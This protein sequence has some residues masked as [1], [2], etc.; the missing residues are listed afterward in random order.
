MQSTERYRAFISYS[1]A[2]DGQLAPALQRGLHRLAKPWYRPPPWRTF[3]DQTSLSVTPAL[4]SSIEQALASSGF[5]ILLASPKAAASPWVQREIDWWLAHRPKDRLLLALT[6]GSLQWDREAHDFDPASSNALPSNLRGV[7]EQEPLWVDL[8]W[9]RS[10][11]QVSLRHPAFRN[12]V[13]ELAAPLH[14]VDKERLVGEDMRQQRRFVRWRNSAIGALATV[15]LIAVGAATI[16]VDRENQAREEARLALSR[17]LAAEAT[18]AAD[19]Q[20]DLGLVL[21]AQAYATRPTAQTKS[22]L[23][24]VLLRSPHLVS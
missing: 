10:T 9:A 22:G 4:W 2:A 17:Q 15:T 6:E 1:H 3:R 18:A 16:A 20:L 5:F 12:A 19:D 14:G 24:Q 8:R 13:A 21:A 7:F 11:Q 23:L